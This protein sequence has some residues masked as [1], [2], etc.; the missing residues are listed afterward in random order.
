V[1]KGQTVEVLDD[2][3]PEWWQI[4]YGGR[5]GWAW[6]E[7]LQPVDAEDAPDEP[8]D[9]PDGV[10]IMKTLQDIREETREI[11]KLLTELIIKMG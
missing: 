11:L 6:A 3:A 2:T 4:K 1:E 5:I 10:E 7:Y 8:V 9:E